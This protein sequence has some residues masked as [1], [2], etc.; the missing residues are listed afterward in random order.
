M[1]FLWKSEVV[2]LLHREPTEMQQIAIEL[3]TFPFP[4]PFPFSLFVDILL[5]PLDMNPRSRRLTTKMLFK[6]SWCVRIIENAGWPGF[7][8]LGQQ[9]AYIYHT[10]PVTGFSQTK[11][12]GPSPRSP[13]VLVFPKIALVYEIHHDKNLNSKSQALSHGLL[14]RFSYRGNG[15]A[16]PPKCRCPFCT[17]VGG[18]CL[19]LYSFGS[20]IGPNPP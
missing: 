4:F 3:L 15:M 20:W 2:V 17:L 7:R 9:R 19:G 5:G 6:T 1:A 12:P 18:S 13:T 11:P 14:V 10:V 16:P 8:Y